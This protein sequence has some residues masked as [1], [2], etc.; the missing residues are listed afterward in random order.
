[1]SICKH[2]SV[3]YIY[4]LHVKVK[5][6]VDYAGVDIFEMEKKG[7]TMSHNVARLCEVAKRFRIPALSDVFALA[8]FFFS[9][10]KP[11][12]YL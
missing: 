5:Y 2:Y 12:L 10:S 1:M 8:Q 9:I 7:T 11:V 6:A 4:Y 3:L